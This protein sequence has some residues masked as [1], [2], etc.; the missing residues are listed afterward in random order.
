MSK[1]LRL[2]AGID[3]HVHLRDPGGTHKETF[4]TGTAAALAGGY[5]CVL[6]MPNNRPP[7]TSLKTLAAKERAA[8][9][10]VCD[11][12]FWWGA[13]RKNAKLAPE[14]AQRCVGMKVYMNHTFGPLLVEDITTLTRQFQ[15]WPA[16]RPIAVHAEGPAMLVAM[17]LARLCER[18]VH[19]CHVS[20]AW[21][22]SWIREVKEQGSRITCEVTPHHLFLTKDDARALGSLGKMRPPLGTA[23]DRQALWDNLDVIDMLATDHAPHTLE[24]KRG[25]KP[26]PG[27]PGLET[28]LPLMLTAVAEG[29]LT[30]ERL[31][32]LYHDAPARLFGIPTSPESFVVVETDVRATIRGDILQTK[33]HWTPFEGMEVGARVL[34]TWVRGVQAWDGGRVRVPPGFGQRVAPQQNTS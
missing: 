2:P 6:D 21:Q 23:A 3:P 34:E 33:C 31:V 25:P 4:R 24:E 12:G 5:A 27:V 16:D 22:I 19:V 8:A 32:E 11:Y 9:K 18:W 17:M 29:R 28:A 14:A 15:A 26:P 13:T 1:I 10:A 20:E 30:L 7:V